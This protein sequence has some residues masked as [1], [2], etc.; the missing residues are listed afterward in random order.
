MVWIL[1]TSR[2]G[3]MKLFLKN[4]LFRYENKAT[5]HLFLS[6]CKFGLIE[7]EQKSFRGQINT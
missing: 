5:E 7:I 3:T 2:G 1:A 4:D 6:P